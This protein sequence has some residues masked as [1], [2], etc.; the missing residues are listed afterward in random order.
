MYQQMTPAQKA[1][2][3]L[4]KGHMTFCLHES[5]PGAYAYFTFLRDPIERA[6]SHYRFVR[7]TP[8]H[9][10]HPF[11]VGENLDLKTTLDRHLDFM[12]F[13][14]HVRLL[15]GVWHD[16]RPGQ[17]TVDHLRLAQQRLRDHF[18]VIGLTEDF[19][20]SLLLLSKAFGWKALYYARRNVTAG[21][22]ETGTLPPDT[23]AALTEAN[24]LD[25][26]LFRYG[27]ELFAQQVTGHESLVEEVAQ[28]RRKNEKLQP[29]LDLYWKL[30]Q[31]SIRTKIREARK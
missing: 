19:D 27:R 22:L 24:R 21:R 1:R 28:F 10:A 11:S 9:A 17:C 16:L 30:R 20:T 12:L 6:V 7:R 13:N 25:L 4:I 2:I 15:S 5:V 14:A 26:D 18:T 29:F 23:L 31:F 8:E 3:K